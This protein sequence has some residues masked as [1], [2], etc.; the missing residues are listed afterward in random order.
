M[1]PTL[2]VEGDKLIATAQLVAG[3]D[4]DKDGVHALSVNASV[5]I[6]ADGSEVL[7]ELLKSSELAQKA[8]ELLGKLGL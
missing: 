5:E 6:V 8:K 4:T 1:K 3:V 7:E 2:K